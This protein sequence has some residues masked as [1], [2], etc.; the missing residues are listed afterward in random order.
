MAHLQQ[1]LFFMR[2]KDKFPNKFKNCTILDIGS[3]DINGNNRHLFENYQYIGVDVGAGP[4]VDVVAKGNEYKSDTLFDIVISSE[5]FEHD[6]YYPETLKNCI[7]LT[8]PG[9]LFTFTCA[10]DGRAEHGT[11]RSCPQDSPLLLSL[12]EWGDYYKNLNEKDIRE[13][14]NPD[15]HFSEYHFEYNPSAHDLYFW[16]VKK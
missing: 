6:M 5:C 10:S 15:E 11:K 2:V 3:L 16:G 8:K 4:N 13:V 12:G 7:L 1:K 9:G 14:F